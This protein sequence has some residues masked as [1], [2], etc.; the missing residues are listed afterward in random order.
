MAVR[1]FEKKNDRHVVELNTN[2][3][4]HCDLESKCDYVELRTP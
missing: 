4:K 3:I 2:D 1:F